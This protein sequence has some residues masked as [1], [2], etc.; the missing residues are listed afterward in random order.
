[1]QL[2]CQ[3]MPYNCNLKRAVH[4]GRVGDE[5]MRLKGH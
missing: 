4:D 1:M 5:P 3:G 2:V